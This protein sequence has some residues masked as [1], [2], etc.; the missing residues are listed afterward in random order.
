MQRAKSD[1]KSAIDSSIPPKGG[2]GRGS[3][4]RSADLSP[5]PAA[6]CSSNQELE[7]QKMRKRQKAEQKAEE[8]A[9]L[10]RQVD[11]HVFAAAGRGVAGI[12]VDAHAAATP[13]KG[14][15]VAGETVREFDNQE[16]EPPTYQPKQVSPEANYK[17]GSSRG[18]TT[19]VQEAAK[20]CF[21][22]ISNNC[23]TLAPKVEEI[24]G[25]EVDALALQETRL[26]SLLQAKLAAKMAKEKWQ[27][28]FG[29]PTS[30]AASSS[31]V[32]SATNAAKGGVAIITRTQ[33]PAKK[34]L[35]IMPIPSSCG[36]SAAG[37]RSLV[38]LDKGNRHVRIA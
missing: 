34:R 27:A 24:M 1:G 3:A 28:F 21:K 26:S 4:L 38:A 16:E 35:L 12:Q 22:I 32:A 13:S 20:G 5:V 29:R 7:H 31:K 36:T 9:E 25:L 19:E 2:P 11:P 15:G 30:A 14:R 6:S 10:R 23:A 8:T 18:R 37:R 17:P 33:V